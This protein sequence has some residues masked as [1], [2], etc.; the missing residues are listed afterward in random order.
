MK[1]FHGT[2][3][4]DPENIYGDKQEGFNINYTSDRNLLGKGIYFAEKS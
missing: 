2:S 4:T 3:S 1:L